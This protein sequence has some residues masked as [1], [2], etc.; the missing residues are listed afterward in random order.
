MELS[1]RV[2]LRHPGPARLVGHRLRRADA[3]GQAHRPHQ[4]ADD[5]HGGRAGDG[6]EQRPAPADGLEAWAEHRRASRQGTSRLSTTSSTLSPHQFKFLIDQLHR[7]QQHARRGPPGISGRRR[8]S[9]RSSTAASTKG[10]DVTKGGAAYNSSGAAIIGLADVTDSLMVIKKLVFDEK[11]VTFADLKKAVDHEFRER[12][13]RCYAMV[14][15][16]GAALRLRQRRG[17]GDGQPGNHVGPRPLRQLAALPGRQIHGGFLV[18]VAT[19]WPS[20]P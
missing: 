6:H 4:H 8:C 7:V 17:R 15:Q 19:T 3:L 10:K 13:R 11:K 9:R 20:G 18:H 5:E 2:Q 12:S 14:T 16:E 1:R